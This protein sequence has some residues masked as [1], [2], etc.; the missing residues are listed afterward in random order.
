MATARRFS[1]ATL[2]ELAA[3]KIL[4]VRTA[5][6]HHFTGVWVVVV[7]GRAFVLPWNGKPTGWYRA[8]Q[9]Q[10]PGSIRPAGRGIAIRAGV[11]LAGR[12]R[13]TATRAGAGK[14]ATKASEK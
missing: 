3:A 1:K 8:F 4:G 5:T 9:A 7:E 2:D 14:Y 12:L 11:T 10:P 6:E 13:D